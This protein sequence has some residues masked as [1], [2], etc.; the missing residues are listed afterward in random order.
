MLD[1]R[2]LRNEQTRLISMSHYKRLLGTLPIFP[3]RCHLLKAIDHYR[4]RTTPST[5]TPAARAPAK[6]FSLKAGETISISIGGRK[7]GSSGEKKSNASAGSGAFP[8]L[9]PPPSASDVRKRM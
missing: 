5:S 2:A 6:D 9:P 8:L 4:R 1:S 3:T 7:A